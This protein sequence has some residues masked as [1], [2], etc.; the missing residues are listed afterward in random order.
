[1]VLPKKLKLIF[2]FYFILFLVV[3]GFSS[4]ILATNDQSVIDT[5]SVNTQEEKQP[6][7]TSIPPLPGVSQSVKT[8]SS[9]AVAAEI[10]DGE[11]LGAFSF[12]CK[13]IGGVLKFLTG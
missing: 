12:A 2:F 7:Q 8:A 10:E 5:T 4:L 1:M 3:S 9:T 13:A 6:N 11:V